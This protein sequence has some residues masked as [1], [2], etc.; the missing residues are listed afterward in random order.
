V[1]GPFEGKRLCIYHS[2]GRIPH[3]GVSIW[4][5]L[6]SSVQAVHNSFMYLFIWL[7]LPNAI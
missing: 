3:L 6:C 7:P 1:M 4:V 2:G 5:V